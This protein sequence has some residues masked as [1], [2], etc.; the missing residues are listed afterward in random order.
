MMPMSDELV[1]AF[2]TLVGPRAAAAAGRLLY[3]CAAVVFAHTWPP[4]L[5][6]VCQ[7]LLGEAAGYKA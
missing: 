6:A 3:R 5:L 2:F 7:L 1:F 4:C